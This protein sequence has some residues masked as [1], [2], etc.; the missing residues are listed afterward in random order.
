VSLMGVNVVISEMLPKE[1]RQVRFPRTK[2][3]R[4]RKKW[5]KDLRNWAMVETMGLMFAGDTAYCSRRQWAA[6][7][8]Q[9]AR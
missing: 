3:K 9:V 4:I 1:W 7:V 2:R 5:R 8:R 6:L